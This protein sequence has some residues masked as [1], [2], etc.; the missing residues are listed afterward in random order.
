MTEKEIFEKLVP[1][2]REITGARKE[3]V[4]MESGLMMDLG[5]E[6]IDLLDF[7]FLIEEEFGIT[8]E[9]D[10]FEKQARARI[11]GGTYET[12]GFLTS[13]A[14]DELKIALPEVPAE[15]FKSGLKKIELPGI[16]NVAVFVHLIQRK[17]AEKAQEVNNAKQ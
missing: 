9:A 6:S 2:V 14:L 4:K 13:Q 16:L 15:Q 8:I 11:P 17:L 3:Q 7:S 1:L 12:D 10:E 5:A